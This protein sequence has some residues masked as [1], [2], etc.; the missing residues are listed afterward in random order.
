[1]D[2]AGNSDE[3][4]ESVLLTIDTSTPADTLAPDTEL[5][6]APRLSLVTTKKKIKLTFKFKASESGSTFQ[7]R[8]DGGDYTACTSPHTVKV[9]ATSKSK[10]H[11]FK[12]RAV[13]SS[14]N[15]DFSTEKWVGSV[16][17]KKK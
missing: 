17:R 3:S 12:V 11:R 1:M 13:D 15:I 4:P 16:K 7:C 2:L 14:G 9:K 6:S 5:T 10:T 8:F